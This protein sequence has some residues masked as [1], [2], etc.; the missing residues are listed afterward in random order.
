MTTKGFIFVCFC[1]FNLAHA[2]PQ[3]Q[4]YLQSFWDNARPGEL[5]RSLD[6]I[7]LSTQP[8]QEEGE[9][10]HNNSP[11]YGTEN[12]PLQRRIDEGSEESIEER[13]PYDYDRAYE[14]FVNKYFEDSVTDALSASASAEHADN[15]QHEAETYSGEEEESNEAS[16]P[17]S[18]ASKQSAK[19]EICKKIVRDQQNCLICKNPRNGE[20]SESCSYNK[21]TKPQRYAFEKQKN[22]RKYRATPKSSENKDSKEHVS[23]AKTSAS[24]KKPIVHNPNKSNNTSFCTMNKIKNKICFN[25]ETSKGEKVTKCY[26]EDMPIKSNSNGQTSDKKKHEKS[27]Q[28]I[29]KRTLMHSYENNPHT[30]GLNNNT[31]VLENP[32]IQK[33]FLH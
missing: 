31:N 3:Y 28:R 22:Y 1:Y 27:H 25:C 33:D 4:E 30:V 9:I 13:S 24:L 17:A 8:V 16:D 26:A 21:E 32:L 12:T 7:I 15:E 6:T 10:N 14:E 29:F 2:R 20:K 23:S 19:T 11:N 5:L 18:E